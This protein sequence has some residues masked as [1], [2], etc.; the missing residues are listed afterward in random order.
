MSEG[1]E[2]IPVQT[3]NAD[4]PQDLHP[5]PQPLH[6]QPQPLVPVSQQKPLHPVTEKKYGSDVVLESPKKFD[7]PEQQD[8]LEKVEESDFRAKFEALQENIS[9]FPA[10]AIRSMDRGDRAEAD[11]LLQTIANDMDIFYKAIQDSDLFV[12]TLESINELAEAESTYRYVDQDGIG[13]DFIKRNLDIIV[14]RINA[15]SKTT[16]QE[17]TEAKIEGFS[18]ILILAEKVQEPQ[19]LEANLDILLNNLEHWKSLP[20]AGRT[21]D[22]L[23]DYEST[24]QPLGYQRINKAL[25]ERV[26]K[27]SALG[28]SLS[29][30]G[31][32]VQVLRENG[33]GAN[34]AA[35]ML[36]HRVFERR[37]FD[38]GIIKDWSDSEKYHLE[39]IE[40]LEKERPGIVNVL[41]NEYGISCFGLYPQDLLIKQYDSRDDRSMPFGIYLSARGEPNGP[42]SRGNVNYL[43]LDLDKEMK[44]KFLLRIV[45]AGGR[46]SV[47]K[48]L[49][50]LNKRYGLSQKIQFAIVTGHGEKDRIIFGTRSDQDL[51]IED[52][53][54]RSAS[55]SGEI[56]VEH[57]IIIL[58]SCTTG[59]EG[60][61]AQRLSK[62]MQAEVIAPDRPGFLDAI[63]FNQEGEKAMLDAE[64]RST[65]F[66][67]PPNKMRYVNGERIEET[68]LAA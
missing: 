10:V 63:S 50:K 62:A 53:D 14:G 46:L 43:L 40:A 32:I 1:G 38:L 16:S 42:S 36:I 21:L 17:T 56:F 30:C 2:G 15:T 65:S 51:R 64:F 27:K 13:T 31:E 7:D 23:F 57:P 28:E 6:P 44:G 52:L 41:H 55:K 61:I 45:E 3:S 60:G 19:L 4:N 33:D 68:A 54:G 67:T 9:R 34:Y 49:L 18:S 24:Q 12:K 66:S 58:E 26:V 35:R 11:E 29:D 8:K 37:G 5:K 22:Q 48:N 59:A 47:I 39:A 20:L 25:E